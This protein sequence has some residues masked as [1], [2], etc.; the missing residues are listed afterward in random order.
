MKKRFFA[1]FLVV[2]MLIGCASASYIE[3]RAS[4]YLDSYMVL[5]TP[6]DDHTMTVDFGV[7]GTG[8]MT[9]IGV[10]SI[11]I[12]EQIPDGRWFETMTY[13]P[14]DDYDD[15]YYSYDA[16]FHSGH[17]TFIGQPGVIYRATINVYA[18]NSTGGDTRSLTSNGK[19]CK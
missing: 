6:N 15:V 1:S 19:A 18:G 17:I 5:L 3:P 14:D 11:V 16:Y 13:Y 9:K 2:I 7:Y 8:K 4:Y 10:D 12:E